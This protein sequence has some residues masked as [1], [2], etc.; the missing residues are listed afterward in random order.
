MKDQDFPFFYS[1]VLSMLAFVLGCPLRVVKWLVIAP[2]I[3]SSF[4]RMW[5][6]ARVNGVFLCMHLSPL[7]RKGFARATLP[8][9]EIVRSCLAWLWWTWERGYLALPAFWWVVG[10]EGRELEM[11]VSWGRVMPTTC[12][13]FWVSLNWLPDP[14]CHCCFS[15]SGPHYLFA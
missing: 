3:V 2:N 4:S 8:S 1:A 11:A 14:Q 7:N 9:R 12:F 5:R 13:I 6:R 10:K 15:S